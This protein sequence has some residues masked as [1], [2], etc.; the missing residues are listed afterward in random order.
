MRL[1]IILT[2][3]LLLASCSKSKTVT[4]SGEFPKEIEAYAK[5]TAE[6][7]GEK[8]RYSLPIKE[9]RYEFELDSLETGI[10]ELV[11]EWTTPFD[12]RYRTL[13]NKEGEIVEKYMPKGYWTNILEKKSISTRTSPHNI[14]SSLIIT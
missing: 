13:K 9:G 14:L 6:K 4:I 5:I 11:I 8:W 7:N 2:A 12:K 10:Y 1:I 3:T